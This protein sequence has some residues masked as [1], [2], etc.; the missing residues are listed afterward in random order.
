MIFKIKYASIKEIGK[1]GCENMIS[2]D[3]YRYYSHEVKPFNSFYV[4]S[5]YTENYFKTLYYIKWY[6]IIN[7]ILKD[8][9]KNLL[10]H[11]KFSN[12]FC[13]CPSYAVV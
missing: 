6:K 7:T 11:D 3:N 13:P 5:K 4:V 12:V 8:I 10:L 1:R 2:L 9:L